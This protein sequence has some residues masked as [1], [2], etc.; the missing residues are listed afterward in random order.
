MFI[1]HKNETA[2][3]IRAKGNLSFNSLNEPNLEYDFIST[4]D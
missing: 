1:M 2:R 3:F 4:K